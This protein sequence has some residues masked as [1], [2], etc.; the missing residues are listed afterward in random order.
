MEIELTRTQ[1]ACYDTVL[2]TTVLHEE[3]MEMIVSD[4]CPDILRIV[5][6]A[7][8]VCLKSKE[9][10]EGRAEVTGA[11]RCAILYLPDGEK[12][13]RRIEANIPFSCTADCAGISPACSV[14]AVPRVLCADTRVLNP[15][16]VL[17][18]VNLAVDFRVF[19]PATASLCTGAEC[20]A[21]NN[22]VEQ[23]R[24]RH[25]TYMVT[26]VQEKPFTFSDDLSIPGS[27]PEVAELLKCRA[28][29]NCT[30]SK[31]IGNKLIFKGEAALRICYRAVDD[32]VCTVDFELPFSQIMEVSGVGEEADCSLNVLL[33]E[34]S[35]TLGAGDGRTVSV[36][37]GLLAQAV[38]REERYIELLTDIYSTACDLTAEMQSNTFNDLVENNARRQTTREIVETETMA[39]SAIDA[40][41]NVGA[42][43]QSRE[44]NWVTFSVEAFVSVLYLNEENE[45]RAANRRVNVPCQVELPE[46]CAC[47]CRSRGTGEVFATPTAGGIEVRFDL[48]FLYLALS[49]KRLAAVTGVQAGE[50]I[51]RDGEKEPSIVLRV[52]GQ[53]RLW[54]IAKTY[55]TTMADIMQAN[56][57]E[58]GGA[59][60]GKLLLIP[61]KR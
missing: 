50:N 11:V 30:E 34:L 41:V 10:M 29:L 22:S 20:A 18:R 57:L 52:V 23:L 58:P 32:T 46:G 48:D 1:L 44:G 14:V 56:E 45:V 33:T 2:D 31:I 47:S 12:G 3:T 54:D 61:R 9:A 19:C 42:V 17:V 39:R 53:E 7:G 51:V 26:C 6:T 21:P 8:T 28:N 37:M 35:C 40:S 36:S 38:I 55:R 59:L 27:R 25:K 4:A 60:E 49:S 43:T 16:K 5:D 15:R 24:E 13:V